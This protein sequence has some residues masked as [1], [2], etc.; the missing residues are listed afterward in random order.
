MLRLEEIMTTELV[1]VAPEVSVREAMG[2]LVTEHLSG[3]PVVA[4]NKVVGV[5]SVTDLLAFAVAPPVIPEAYEREAGWEEIEEQSESVDADDLTATWFAEPDIN[6]DTD[7]AE[8]FNELEVPR[9]RGDRLAQHTVS[10]VMTRNVCALPPRTRV[11]TAADFMRRAA[12]HRVLV[13]E[14]DALLGIVTLKDIAD[15]VADHKLTE[16]TYVFGKPTT[17]RVIRR[18]NR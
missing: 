3:A 13:M 7:V 12:I 1:S 8:R 2:L 6:A 16:R 5:V 10:D 4:Q 17:R 11:D 15:A 14:N 18:S 9:T